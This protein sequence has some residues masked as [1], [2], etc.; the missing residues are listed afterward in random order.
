VTAREIAKKYEASEDWRG[1]CAESN[2]CI[3]FE[4]FVN[5]SDRMGGNGL[6]LDPGEEDIC[7]NSSGERQ[8]TRS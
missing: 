4:V 2:K 6:S 1:F 5:I 3:R 7:A 8:R